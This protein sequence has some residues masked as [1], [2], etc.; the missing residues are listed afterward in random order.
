MRNSSSSLFIITAVFYFFSCISSNTGTTTQSS[1][2]VSPQLKSVFINGDS[3]HYIETGTGD[4]VVF[5]HGSLG[6]YRTWGGQIDTFAKNYRVIAYSRRYAYPNNKT[7]SDSSDYSVT[8]HAKDLNE[9]LKKLNVGPVHLVGHSYGAYTA[10]LTTME[11]PELVRSLTLGEPPVVS[12]LFNVPGG[13]TILNNFVTRVMMPAGEALKANDSIKAVSV[14]VGGVM[15]D[16]LYYSRMP[17]SHRE[18]LMANVLETRGTMAAENPFPPVSC[19]DLAKIKVPVLLVKGE[20]SPPF[21]LSVIGELERCISNRETATMANV[22]HGLQYENPAAFNEIVS[23]F[24]AR[25]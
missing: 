16:S 14:F 12:L 22:S 17:V 18:I 7:V 21:F 23:R 5:V 11:H 24:L 2:D 8:P 6:D 13:D 19:E 3:L 1:T 20:K 15:G 10:L 25:H 4:P 9:F